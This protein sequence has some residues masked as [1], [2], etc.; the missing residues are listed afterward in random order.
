MNLPAIHLQCVTNKLVARAIGMIP[1]GG[2]SGLFYDPDTHGTRVVPNSEIHDRRT[3][4]GVE[5]KEIFDVYHSV[6]DLARAERHFN[7]TVHEVN[8]RVSEL[9]SL[10]KSHPNH[11][12]S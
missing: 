1:I 11:Q 9:V 2:D 5:A 3:R 10:I 8:R 12:K 7:V 6:E 4:L